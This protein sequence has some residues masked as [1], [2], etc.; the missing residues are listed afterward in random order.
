MNCVESELES[1][2]VNSILD[3]TTHFQHVRVCADWLKD[4]IQGKASV[5]D[6]DMVAIACRT[7]LFRGL[8]PDEFNRIAES[9]GLRLE[10]S[11]KCGMNYMCSMPVQRFRTRV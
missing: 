7:A 4:C 2:L 5:Q 10:I 6:K 1:W 9:L 8:M 3:S 11:R